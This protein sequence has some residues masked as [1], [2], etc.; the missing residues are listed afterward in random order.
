MSVKR[1]INKD[2]IP[3]V[4][5]RV[6]QLKRAVLRIGIFGKDD[7]MMVMIASV[8]EFGANIEAKTS[9]YLTIPINKKAK[10]KKASDFTGL[11]F[12]ESENGELFLAKEKGKDQLEFYFWLTKKV[13]IPER[14]FIRAGY[15]KNK[16][17]I[18]KRIELNLH[19]FLSLEI[20]ADEF[21]S[22][23]GEYM[24]SLIKKYMTD[25]KDPP[26]SPTTLASKAPKNNPLIDTGQLRQHIVWKLERR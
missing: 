22:N 3:R 20:S 12:I 13:E 4:K 14:S 16:Q 2:N 23:T 26:N 8:H 5:T 1:K 15:D 9:K 10:G 21:W 24:V 17:K 18:F 25:L 6:N 11:I 7:S 19:K